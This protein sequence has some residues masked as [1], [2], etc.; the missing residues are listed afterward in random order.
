MNRGGDVAIAQLKPVIAMIRIRLI[1][2][3][4]CMKRAVKP[5][6][7][8]VA[9]EHAPGAISA[10]RRRRKSDDQYARFRIAEARQRFRPVILVEVSSR[11]I[12]CAG[13]TPAHQTGAFITVNDLPV[14]L[15]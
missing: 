3:A 11:R 1:G 8:A 7:A 12:L 14:E 9:G 4:G 5:I 6:A 2:K 10:V 13:F 15:L